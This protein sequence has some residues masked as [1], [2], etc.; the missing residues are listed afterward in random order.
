M[1]QFVPPE[2]GG[3]AHVPGFPGATGLAFGEAQMPV[4]QSLLA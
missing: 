3:G 4:Q 1:E 2:D